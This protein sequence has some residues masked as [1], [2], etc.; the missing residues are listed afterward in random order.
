[1]DEQPSEEQVD[2]EDVGVLQAPLLEEDFTQHTPTISRRA[3]SF[4]NY[5]AQTRGYSSAVCNLQ[6]GAGSEWSVATSTGSATY[7]PR[8]WWQ[9]Q[10]SGSIVKFSTVR[11]FSNQT[12]DYRTGATDIFAAYKMKF[13]GAIP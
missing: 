8:A 12:L 3:T 5:L 10:F 13:P 9:E 2:V 4:P 7:R 1:M 6:R 11:T